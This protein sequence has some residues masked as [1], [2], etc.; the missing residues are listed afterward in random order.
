MNP[1]QRGTFTVLNPQKPQS[2]SK[3]WW[4]EAARNPNLPRGDFFAEADKRTPQM[5]A[6]IEARAVESVRRNSFPK[7]YQRENT[8]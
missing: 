5:S 7:K 3:T 2:E 8:R 6:S 1:M 4:Q